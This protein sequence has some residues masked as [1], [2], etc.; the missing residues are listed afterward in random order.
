VDLTGALA[1]IRAAP[2][3][4]EACEREWTIPA[5]PAADWFLAVL[6]G[7]SYPIVPQM[8]DEGQEEEL[9]DLI[10]AGDLGDAELRLLNHDALEV[11]AGMPW[12][13]AERLIVS[14]AVQWRIV[15]G[16]LGQAGV[17]LETTP[18]GSVLATIY[19]LAVEHL[20]KEGRFAFDAQLTAPPPGTR[21]TDFDQTDYQ[22]EF[23]AM[24]KAG[25]QIH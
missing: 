20:D 8:L 25:A 19:V 10:L 17:D 18:L 24:L 4:V 22:E 3:I 9:S 23:R 16:L 7:D 13:Q 2:I 14:A 1:G 5:L 12:Y 11:A 15:G 6:S 21:A